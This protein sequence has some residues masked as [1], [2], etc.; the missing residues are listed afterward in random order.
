LLEE[1][2][3]DL[4]SL[5]AGE[6]LRRRGYYT[7]ETLRSLYASGIFRTLQNVRP[8]RE[9]P[10]QTMQLMQFNW[11]LDRGVLRFDP[12][13]RRL[14]IDYGRYPAAVAALLR[15]V[16]AVQ[17]AG[18]PARAQAFVTRWASWDEGLHG[19]VAANMRAAQR[20][21]YRLFTYAALG[22]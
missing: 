13:S 20:V 11:F 18:D 17:D 19:R 4:V 22:E 1:L 8:R 16:L 5:F 21:R 2:K 15:E 14:S 7:D 3:A 6:E 10:Y 9:Q 12:V